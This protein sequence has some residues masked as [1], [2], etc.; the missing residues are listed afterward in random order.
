MLD[1]Q[2]SNQHFRIAEQLIAYYPDVTINTIMHSKLSIPAV[3]SH[4]TETYSPNL[5]ANLN[6]E[7]DI[8]IARTQGE[9]IWHAHPETDEFFYILSGSLTLEIEGEKG[10]EG[11]ALEKGDVF[12]VPRG[13]KHRPVGDAEIMLIEKVGVMNTGDAGRS[14]F[15]KEVADARLVE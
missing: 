10:M 8:K 13:V 9:F 15:T 7:Y 3:L 4:I 12:V 11:I 2:T 6:K 1:S 14:E 5:V